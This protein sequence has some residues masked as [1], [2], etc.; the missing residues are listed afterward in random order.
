MPF[1]E[2]QCKACGAHHEA[3]QKM[4]DAALKKCPACGRSQLVR[5]L[6]APVFR[7]KGAGWYE[8]DFKSDKEAKRNLAGGEEAAAP[9]AAGDKEAKVD[10]PAAPATPPK[11]DGETTG[12]TADAGKTATTDAKAPADG[13]KRASADGT[14]N[15]KASGTAARR[16]PGSRRT[17]RKGPKRR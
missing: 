6:S 16:P 2:Y 13:A 14:G 1:Y 15:G 8:T 3:M 10:G 17:T 12:G 5:L 4:S 11:A 7:L 9:P